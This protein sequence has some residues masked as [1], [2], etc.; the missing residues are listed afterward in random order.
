MKAQPWSSYFSER[1]AK[2]VAKVKH[3]VEDNDARPEYEP[4]L[5]LADRKCPDVVPC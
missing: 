3:V 2:Q 4:F 5:R 1:K